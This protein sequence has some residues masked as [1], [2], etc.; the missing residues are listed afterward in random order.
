MNIRK[1]D[2]YHAYKLASFYEQLR[3][4]ENA[5]KWYEKTYKA[6][7]KKYL[8]ALFNQA[9]MQR[10]LGDYQSSTKNFETFKKKYKKNK[11][12]KDYRKVISSEIA[13]NNLALEYIDSPLNIMI[14]H[15]N[16]SINKAYMEFSPFFV[17]KTSSISSI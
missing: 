9:Q 6:N 12:K 2:S 8:I 5:E 11:N 1:S 7:Q 13:G 3:D 14:I 17:E 4:Y 10:N 16:E 15:L